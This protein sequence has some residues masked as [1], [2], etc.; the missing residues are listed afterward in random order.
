MKRPASSPL[1][2]PRDSSARSRHP[3]YS[4]ASA[5]SATSDSS[6]PT[7]RFH[8]QGALTEAFDVI[9]SSSWDLR[10]SFWT[11][12]NTL[13][14]RDATIARMGS[15]VNDLERELSDR[16]A[17]IARRD[18]QIGELINEVSDLSTLVDRQIEMLNRL[19]DQNSIL[20]S[21]LD[22]L[23][24]SIVPVIEILD[25]EPS[26]AVD[27]APVVDDVDAAPVAP[28]DD[29]DDVV[30]VDDDVVVDDVDVVPEE[31]T[32][33]ICLGGDTVTEPLI[34][35]SDCA[36]HSHLHCHSQWNGDSCYMCQKVYCKLVS[37]FPA[38][39]FTQSCFACDTYPSY[40]V[41]LYP[42]SRCAVAYCFNCS[43]RNR[44]CPCNN[45]AC[46]TLDGLLDVITHRN[47][48]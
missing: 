38:P 22:G 32:C 27:A 21:A 7:S 13:D 42:Q 31:P 34:A 36:S 3:T 17:T 43:P 40:G 28:D 18:S 30:V 35:H 19:D 46:D 16:D 24:V 6:D 39:S 23:R 8:P 10:R 5:A 20:K 45:P 33:G 9:S 4:A 44:L 11:L 12:Q 1:P 48:Q 41:V 26:V 47:N 25:E 14:E 37:D 15:Q 2:D 29:D